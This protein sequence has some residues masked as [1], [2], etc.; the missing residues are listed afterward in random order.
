MSEEQVQETFDYVCPRCGF[1]SLRWP[2]AE[3]RDARGAQH[4]EE[5]RTKVPMP[6]LAVFRGDVPPDFWDNQAPPPAPAPQDQP[7]EGGEE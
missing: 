6:E 3:Q 5:H 1:S 2:T 4:E 7:D